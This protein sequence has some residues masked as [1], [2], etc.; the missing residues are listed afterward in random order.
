MSGP[1]RWTFI[2]LAVFCLACFVYL[3]G[4]LISNNTNLWNP[5]GVMKRL[6]VYFSLNR[7]W[8]GQGYPLPEL[9]DRN[10]EG[11][12]IVLDQNI[13][14]AIKHFRG[15]TI[16]TLTVSG[17]GGTYRIKVP[18]TF[19]RKKETMTLTKTPIS[20][21]VRLSM[22]G[23]ADGSLPDLGA[24]RNSILRFYHAL[25]N[26]IALHPLVAFHEESPSR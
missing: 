7:A 20:E 24:T 13:M 19:W 4:D 18:S 22:S 14:R 15:W 1:V 9:M 11:D 3:G 26:E 23:K 25:D 10:Y 21:G 12:V 2:G 8:T 5:P 16:E 17:T 6:S